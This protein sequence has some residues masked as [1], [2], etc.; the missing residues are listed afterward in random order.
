MVRLGFISLPQSVDAI[1]RCDSTE[2][3][4]QYEECQS[5]MNANGK[6]ARCKVPP[7]LMGLSAY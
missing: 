2:G 5:E 4:S 6:D 7:M 1:A 3:F